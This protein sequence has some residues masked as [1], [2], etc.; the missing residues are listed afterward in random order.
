MFQKAIQMEVDRIRKDQKE[1]LKS[2]EVKLQ[3]KMKMINDLITDQQNSKTEK[4]SL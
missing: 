1:K 4:Q 3:D 2:Y